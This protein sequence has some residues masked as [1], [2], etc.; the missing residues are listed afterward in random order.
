MKQL[1]REKILYD[2]DT[3]DIFH[4]FKWENIYQIMSVGTGHTWNMCSD[5]GKPATS[6]T[7]KWTK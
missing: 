6:R 4:D 3:D 2:L 1:I 7:G 5:L